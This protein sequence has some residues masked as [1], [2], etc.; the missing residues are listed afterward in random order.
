MG[1]GACLNQIDNCKDL[2][3]ISC[4]RVDAVSGL[5]SYK[6]KDG[7]VVVVEAPVILVVANEAN[8][9]GPITSDSDRENDDFLI[10]RNS[11]PIYAKKITCATVACFDLEVLRITA[12]YW[13]STLGI[14][15]E[16][17]CELLVVGT[18]E[19]IQCYLG[20]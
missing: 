7:A 9:L 19:M 18:R 5:E 14:F 4:E 20:F 2:S 6:D 17:Y 15:F 10:N 8:S 3:T 12:N 16:R 11:P 13:E 1:S